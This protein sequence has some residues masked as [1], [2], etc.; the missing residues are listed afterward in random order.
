MARVAFLG[1][2]RMGTPM[3]LRLAR[4]GH[5]L[6]VWNRSPAQAVP[7]AEAGASVALSPAEACA[8]AEVAIT[9]LADAAALDQVLFGHQ[10]AAAA[11][12]A[13]AILV[14]MSTVGPRAFAAAQARL[15]AGVVAVDA[16]VRGSIREAEEGRLQVYVGASEAVLK[17]VRP[18]LTAFG[19][20]RHVG[21][22][23]TGAAVKLVVNT[24]L[25]ASM[26]A[27][28]EALALGR[29]LGL[30][31]ADLL[32]VL[33]DSPVGALVRSKGGLIET[34]RY[35]ASFRL[36]LAIKDLDLALEAADRAGLDLEEARAARRWLRR[37]AEAGADGLDFAAVVALIDGEVPSG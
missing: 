32:A 35:P 33:Q 24:T 6:T 25:M 12:K 27:V 14:D 4:A 1:L 8:Q 5:A 21:G 20:V 17:R 13:G 10:G 15:P 31:R 22:P 16:P 37:A 23:G 7:L 11:L 36:R 18:V 30:A 2:G 19:D 3:A 28:G 34:G 26:V 9:M 29:A